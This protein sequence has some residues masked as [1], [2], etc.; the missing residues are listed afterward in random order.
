MAETGKTSDMI[1][2][3]V[4]EVPIL[5]YFKQLSPQCGGGETTTTK[6]WRWL[7]RAKTARSPPPPP[8]PL[9]WAL[10]TASESNMRASSPANFGRTAACSTKT[11]HPGLLKDDTAALRVEACASDQDFKKKEFRKIHA[12]RVGDIS[13]NFGRILAGYRIYYVTYQVTRSSINLMLNDRFHC[14]YL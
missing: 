10:L 2:V 3:V 6:N 7:N 11:Q 9:V 1:R 8:P 4:K 12:N 5:A 14:K 13:G